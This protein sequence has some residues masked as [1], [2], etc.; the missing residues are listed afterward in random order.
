MC[1]P[2]LHC[3]LRSSLVA[4]EHM[5]KAEQ[6]T[7]RRFVLESA[8]RRGPDG[9][10]AFEHVVDQSKPQGVRLL[11]KLAFEYGTDAQLQLLLGAAKSGLA[12]GGADQR[13]A[14]E[15]SAG[16]STLKAVVYANPAI[17]ASVVVKLSTTLFAAYSHISK[18]EVARASARKLKYDDGLFCLRGAGTIL[19]PK[20]F[21]EQGLDTQ[22]AD[23]VDVTCGHIRVPGLADGSDVFAAL[24]AAAQSH[25]RLILS[26]PLRA[27][28]A[29]KWETY[30]RRLW[31]KQGAVNLAFAC[32]YFVGC[33][34]LL[35]GGPGNPYA[36]GDDDGFDYGQDALLTWRTSALSAEACIGWALFALASVLN[37]Y[38]AWL[39]ST[40]VRD[41]Q[42]TGA[43]KQYFSS[44][45]N[46]VDLV[47]MVV[48]VALV[49]LIALRSGF[50]PTAAVVGATLTFLRSAKLANGHKKVRRSVP[51]EPTRTPVACT[52]QITQ[53]RALSARVVPLPPHSSETPDLCVLCAARVPRK[54][55]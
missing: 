34:L 2:L 54:H 16:K 42:K 10:S 8:L 55:A 33:G 36:F 50:A 39:E 7:A 40:E 35:L 11:L 1:V 31:L 20:G 26:E 13:D 25:P 47:L 28:I 30:G 9:K 38:F 49:P 27:A 3:V 14:L 5:S 51:S 22:A 45:V 53:S 21:W 43:L 52:P 29:F 48:V 17:A 4:C 23:A 41:A 32:C 18:P 46:W 6:A 19:V 24:V 37:I 12:A 44:W 15:I